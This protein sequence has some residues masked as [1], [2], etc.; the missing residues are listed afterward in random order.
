MDVTVKLAW[1]LR[2]LLGLAFTPSKSEN[3]RVA[4]LEAHV[5]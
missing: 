4:V 5:G 2:L 1:Q 3:V